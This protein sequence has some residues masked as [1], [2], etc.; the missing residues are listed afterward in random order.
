MSLGR[1]H[2]SR[3]IS[4]IGG[5]I[6]IALTLASG[7]AVY[8][9]MQ[10]QA[11]S[12]LIRVIETTL[13]NNRH[14]F[15]IGI[16]S[17]VM[18]SLTVSTRP[19]VMRSLA[20]VNADPLDEK[21]RRDLKWVAQTF[22]LTGF[23]AISFRDAMGTEIAHAGHFASH[24]DLRVPLKGDA[25][26][27]L[28]WDK[29]F[30]LN[31][32]R[33]VFNRDGERIGTAF[34]ET[35]L[36]HLTQAL[37]KAAAIGKTAALAV[38]SEA[39]ENTMHCFPATLNPT[40]RT[41]PR[42]LHGE[43]LPMS[44]ALMGE[45]GVAFAVDSRQQEVVAAYAPLGAWGLGLVLKI[46][47]AELFGP[48]K[49]QLK[50]IVPVLV[51]LLAIGVFLLYWLVTP[52]VRKLVSSEQ[53]LSEI[54][55]RLADVEE[56][57]RFA[58]ESTGAGV[59]DLNL[60]SQRIIIS[61]RCKEMLA[62]AADE[63]GDDFSQWMGQIHPEDLAGVTAL[64]Q[65][66]IDGTLASYKHE[67]RKRGKNGAW[68]WIQEHGMLA[69]RDTENRPTRIIGTCID[70]S[71]RKQAEE[72][73]R[74]QANFDPLTQ[75][76][77][78]R[79]FHDRLAQ[80]IIKCRRAGLAL[81]LL[82]IDLDHFKEINDALGHD[83]GD[84]LLKEAAQRIRGQI[85]DVDT[86][87][88]LG[89]D[90]FTVILTLLNDPG[91]LEAIVQKILNKL[92][93]PFHLGNEVAYVSASIGIT[94]YPDDAQAL[95][96]LIK[97]A[98]QAMYAAKHAGRNRF[99]Y[100]TQSLQESAQERMRLT[101]D[102]RSALVAGELRVA[103]QP[104]VNLATG[105]M[106]KAEA[107][108][109]WQHPKRGM[110]LPA[111]FIPLA[112]ETGL[113]SSIGDWVFKESASWAKRWSQQFDAEFQVSINMSPVQFKGSDNIAMQ[114]WLRHLQTLGLRGDNMI[115]E[116]TEGLLSHAHDEITR[117]LLLFR[118]AGI[119]I[120]LDDFGTG[121]ST[122]AYL[123]RFHIDYLKIDRSFVR[124]LESDAG[125]M[126]LTKGIIVMAHELGLKVIAEGVETTGQQQL[127]LAA[128]CDYAQG[129]LYSKPLAP[130]KLENLLQHQA[131]RCGA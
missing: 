81:G 74:H 48:V 16:D 40:V 10:K 61:S 4:L 88:R 107:L 63:M 59:W 128:G 109:R 78:R 14:N 108:L 96:G 57:A 23:T 12:I 121:Y 77:N 125:D 69:G 131:S 19:L 54:N 37:Y 90:E 18:K 129:E 127:L 52:L 105:R 106:Q 29:Q 36:P 64:H 101:A 115:V 41:L 65:Q 72:T 130:E 110:I 43:H 122:L 60:P 80:E 7:I 113:I 95:E 98:D 83:M 11:E 32:T 1:K 55:Q 46:D 85:R 71:E 79:L 73:I 13:Q 22:L 21:S 39:R 25:Q 24:T 27:Y 120:A 70:I 33:E 3:R 123:K 35:D 104:V 58:L 76:P 50:Y 86:A 38:C 26:A 82:L 68:V 112:E 31:V 17:G 99:H 42:Q 28:L 119:Q 126:A 97:N 34:T 103:F 93:Q 53:Q 6:L 67:H 49:E 47:Q 20:T 89:G 75:L 117:V 8:F 87:A 91:H 118:D 124:D 116:I 114:D 94:L 15:E 102:L 51:G 84:L 100:F 111:E 56:R 30:V 45:S 44:R 2:P 5:L 92:A 66:L 9:L 62:Y